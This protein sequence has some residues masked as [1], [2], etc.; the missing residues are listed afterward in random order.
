[1]WGGGTASAWILVPGGSGARLARLIHTAR[2]VNDSQPQFAVQ[3]VSGRWGSLAAEGSPHSGWPTTE[4][5]DL[6][7]SRQLPPAACWLNTGRCEGVR[8][9]SRCTGG[10]LKT[11]ATLDEALRDAELLLLLVNMT[12]LQPAARRG[13][14]QTDARRIVDAVN[15]WDAKKWQ[16]AGFT[17]QR[18]GSG[19]LV[20]PP[21]SSWQKVTPFPCND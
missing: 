6:R 9:F 20:K 13:G 14:R 18:L 8:P 10:G 4:R 7:E 3:V 12:S 11:T 17:Y 21:C 1:V 15:G 16:A 2:L 19:S 5:D